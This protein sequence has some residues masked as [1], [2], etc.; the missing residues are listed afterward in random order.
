MIALKQAFDESRRYRDIDFERRRAREFAKAREARERREDMEDRAD[1][2]VSE[3]ASAVAAGTPASAERIAEFDAKLT[4]YDA[5]VVTALMENQELLDAAS[6]RRDAMLDQAYVMEDGRRVFR[7][8]DGTQV[9]DEHGQ[10]VSATEV[11]PDTIGPARPS[12]EAF[13][14]EQQAIQLLEAER[15]ELLD[16]QQSLDEAREVLNGEP[17]VEE[18]DAIEAALEDDMPDTVRRH[19]G[20]EP[21]EAALESDLDTGMGLSRPTMEM[22]TRATGLDLMRP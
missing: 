11:H 21:K 9:F 20:L 14:T 6:E 5:A 12:W 22:A 16:Y 18:L 15:S 7:T 8:E 13:R 17:T 1:D 19:A 4:Q 10:A 2:A 3:F